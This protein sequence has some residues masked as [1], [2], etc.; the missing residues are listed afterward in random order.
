MTKLIQG[1]NDFK[2]WCLNNGDYGKKLLSEFVG[3][4]VKTDEN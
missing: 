3:I 2:T 4:E 1:E